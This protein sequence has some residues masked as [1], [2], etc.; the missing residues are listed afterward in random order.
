MRFGLD[1]DGVVYNWD[2]TVRFLIEHYWDIR[3]PES[4]NWNS[5]EHA[6]VEIGREDIWK[7]LWKEGIELGMFRCGHIYKGAGEA[8]RDIG[9]IAEVVVITH[10]PT[11]GVNDTLNWLA[12]QRWPI[13]EVHIMHGRNKSEIPCDVYL[14]DSPSNIEDFYTRTLSSILLWDRPWNQNVDDE[15]LGI[16]RVCNWE[17]VIEWLKAEKTLLGT[18]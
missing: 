3:L 17:E 18:K 9:K 16:T 15:K 10:R 7:W 11:L 1:L 5:F 12:L 6:L 14:D 4:Q 13:T 2:D 8:V